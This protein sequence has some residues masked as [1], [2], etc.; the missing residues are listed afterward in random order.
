MAGYELKL[1]E[2]LEVIREDRRGVSKIETIT[3]NGRLIISE[4]L[5]GLGRLPVKKKDLLTLCVFRETGILSF[6]VT[7]EKI[8]EDNNLTFIEVELRSKIVRHQ[9]RNFVR[10]DTTLPMTVKPLYTKSSESLGDKEA[11]GLLTA[12]RLS[13]ES[14]PKE[15]TLACTTLDISGGGA[16][17]FSKTELL[18]GIPADCEL[19]LSDGFLVEASMRVV[20]VEYERHEGKSVMGAKFIGIQEALRERLIKYIFAE[21]L[22]Q[23]RRGS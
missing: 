14:I 20:R 22:K 19:R 13:G 3:P 11:V 17:F 18:L 1:G 12:R 16:R 8:I 15:E 2:R 4:P 7:A 5:Y 9:R 10:F 23:R 6:T 21:Q